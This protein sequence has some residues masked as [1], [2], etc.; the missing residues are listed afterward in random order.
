M[1][2][3]IYNFLS[4]YVNKNI[5]FIPNP[6][7]AGDQLITYST[8]QIFEELNINF[9]FGDI[10]QV[11]N[12]KTLFYGG[13]GNFIGMYKDCSNFLI[14]NMYNNHIVI[15]PHTIKDEDDIIIS[16]RN[17]VKVIC[18]ELTSYNYVHKIIKNK[19]NVY[20]SKD[21]AFHIKGVDITSKGSGICNAFRNDKENKYYY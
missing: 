13:G 8:I 6:G 21:L 1:E 20:L 9:T 15:L 5:I 11:Y 12:N 18:R 7:N 17:N 19:S 4:E 3:D 14:N 2:I 16:F 10:K